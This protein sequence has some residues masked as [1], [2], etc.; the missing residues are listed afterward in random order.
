MADAEGDDG[1]TLGTGDVSRGPEGDAEVLAD[2]T[3][4]LGRVLGASPPGTSESLPITR[5][6]TPTCLLS[7]RFL[8]D[9][10]DTLGDSEG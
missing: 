9:T 7:T 1:R 6:L 2:G 4:A 3:G 8:V 10:E 5:L